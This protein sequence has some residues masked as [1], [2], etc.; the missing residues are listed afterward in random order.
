KH[1]AKVL[2]AKTDAKWEL[3]GVIKADA[4]G[5]GALEVCQAIDSIRTF[6]VARLSERPPL[7]SSRVKKN[8]LLF[9][10]VNTYDDLMQAIE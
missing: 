3:I 5:H 4:Y 7:K 2:S 8:I 10:A 9:S 1:N 6:A